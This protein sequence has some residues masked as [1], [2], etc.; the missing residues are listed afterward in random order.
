MDSFD[1]YT[2]RVRRVASGL[3]A[4]RLVAAAGVLIA[5][6]LAGCQGLETPSSNAGFRENYEEE[7]FPYPETFEFVKGWRY[8]PPELA[9][10]GF[11]SW[12]GHYRGPGNPGDHV[13]FFIENMTAR[14]WTLRH[15]VEEVDGNKTLEFTKGE[16]AATIELK[17]DFDPSRASFLC[18]LKAHYRPLGPEESPLE[19]PATAPGRTTS[20]DGA[21]VPTSGAIDA[22]QS[23]QPTSH[24]E[25]DGGPTGSQ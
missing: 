14:K 10:S 7:G 20:A 6:G 8:E 25:A 22:G 5:V 4:A 3:V 1:R 19:G 16:E 18:I 17:R 11:R 12:T 13:P 23:K 2:T 15:L 9:G 24:P 21:I